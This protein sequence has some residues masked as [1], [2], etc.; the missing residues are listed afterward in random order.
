MCLFMSM[1]YILIQIKFHININN[2]EL[3]KDIW[4]HKH[5]KKKLFV[6]HSA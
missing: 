4:E 3:L 2:D 6:I 1:I 5:R